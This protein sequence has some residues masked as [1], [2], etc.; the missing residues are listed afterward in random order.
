MNSRYVELVATRPSSSKKKLTIKGPVN[1]GLYPP[2]YAWL[3]IVSDGVPSLGKRVMIGT[4]A[5][6]C[7]ESSSQTSLRLTLSC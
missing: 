5:S 1:A 3:F 4:G 7:L 6:E 2:G